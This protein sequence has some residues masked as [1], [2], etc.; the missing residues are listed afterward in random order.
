MVLMLFAAPLTGQDKTP[1]DSSAAPAD[2]REQL[3]KE[4]PPGFMDSTTSI[5]PEVREVRRKSPGGALLRSLST[6]FAALLPLWPKARSWPG[7]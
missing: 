7:W 1:A 2:S 6:E 4:L 3:Q 5:L